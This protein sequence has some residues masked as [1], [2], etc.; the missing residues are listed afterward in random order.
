VTVIPCD[1]A[2]LDR[3]TR[4]LEAGAAVLL[5]TPS[6]LPYVV[7]ARTAERVNTTKGRPAGQAVALWVPDLAPVAPWIA[8]AA[9]RLPLL[10]R[11]LVD[12]LVTVLVPAR[13]APDAPAWLEPS[14]RDGYLLLAGPSLPA[15]GALHTGPRP[16][17]VSSGNR[18]TQPPAATA[19]EAAAAFGPEVLVLDGDVL[20]DAGVRHAS[21]TMLRFGAGAELEV[22]RHGVQDAAFADGEAYLKDLTDR[23]PAGIAADVA[24]AAEARAAGAG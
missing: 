11:L 15:L 7:A 17:Y 19:E 23:L 1:R 13:V 6:P 4:A 12:E 2:G 16:L 3:V 9:A 14:L 21:S 10:R 20:R 22:V 8:L 5:P 24:D 18:T